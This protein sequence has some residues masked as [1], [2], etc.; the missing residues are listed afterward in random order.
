M[1]MINKIKKYIKIVYVE[2]LRNLETRLPLYCHCIAII[3]IKKKV[4]KLKMAFPT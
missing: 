4:H 1:K 3:L 2:A